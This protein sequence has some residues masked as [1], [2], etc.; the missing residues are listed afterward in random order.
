M[1]V[2]QRGRLD[3]WEADTVIGAQAGLGDPDRA[4]EPAERDR[5]GNE[6]HRPSRLTG[7]HRRPD[8]PQRLG[9]YAHLRQRPGIGLAQTDR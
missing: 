5:Q 4:Q 1:I 8:F 2:E 6:H 7:H 3:D 9:A